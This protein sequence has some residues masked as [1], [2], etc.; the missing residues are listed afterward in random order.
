MNAVV[1]KAKNILGRLSKRHSIATPTK[2][3]HS[4]YACVDPN[5]KFN[6]YY[7]EKIAILSETPNKPKLETM[8][9]FSAQD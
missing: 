5:S 6:K 7:L 2:Q 8:I 9:S 3:T 1:S 4:P